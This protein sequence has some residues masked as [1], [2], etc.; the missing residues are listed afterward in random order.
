M[1]ESKR[2]FCAITFDHATVGLIAEAQ[3]RLLPRMM[4]AKPTARANFHLTLE[5]IGDCDATRE[6]EA[7][8]ALGEACALTRPFVLSS[9][10]LGHFPKRGGSVVWLG[11]AHD[12]GYGMLCAFQLRLRRRL[13]AHGFELPDVAY[14]PHV[15][16]MRGARLPLPHDEASLECLLSEESA[17]LDAWSYPVREAALLWSHRDDDGPLVYDAITRFSLGTKPEPT[18]SD[19][20][21]R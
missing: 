9:G 21:C 14:A 6:R 3:S 13:E 4:R 18:V 11:L 16:L 20:P 12:G 1:S 10:G 8:R 2:L 15:T 5:F 7:G 17:D 19:M